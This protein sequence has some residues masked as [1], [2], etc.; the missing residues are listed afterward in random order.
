MDRQIEKSLGKKFMGARIYLPGHKPKS[1]FFATVRERNEWIE[2]YQRRVISGEFAIVADPD[3]GLQ[4]TENRLLSACIEKFISWAKAAGWRPKTLK[5]RR[6]TLEQFCSELNDPPIG[7]IERAD[8]VRF[9]EKPHWANATRAGVCGA[10]VQFFDYCGNADQGRDWVTQN[11]FLRL[12]WQRVKEDTDAQPGIWSP[13]D[14]AALFLEMPDKYKAGLALLFFTGLRPESELAPINWDNIDFK[15]K[16]ISVKITK[17]RK[18]RVIGNLP[19]NLW[20]WLEKYKGEGSVVH[21]YSGLVQSRRRA[22]NRAGVNWTHDVARHS[23]ASYG[24][25]FG[26]DEWAR[27]TMGHVGGSKVYETNYV[28]NGPTKRE[29]NQYFAILPKCDDK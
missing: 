16:R 18:G 27:R 20:E 15:N 21:S 14:V 7:N 26:G 10:L 12:K 25:W 29:A 22:C 1:K 2:D 17:T 6:R 24:Y 28:N 23:F 8:A 19:P 4:K 13:Q 5:E 3:T 9:I 11:K